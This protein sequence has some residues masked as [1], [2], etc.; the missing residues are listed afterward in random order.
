MSGCGGTVPCYHHVPSECTHEVLGADNDGVLATRRTDVH[1]TLELN[2]PERV[3]GIQVRGEGSSWARRVQVSGVSPAGQF[4][5][6]DE[7]RPLAANWD[8][9]HTVRSY[10]QNPVETIAV[11]LDPQEVEGSPVQTFT[12][13]ALVERCDAAPVAAFYQQLRVCD[14][15]KCQAYCHKACGCEGEFQDFCNRNKAADPTCTVDCSRAWRCCSNLL[16][17]GVALLCLWRAVA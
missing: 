3:V 1:L 12:A 8:G 6:V 13:D 11:T 9:V 14:A 15:L 2:Q 10:F 17:L 16:W 7:G 5:L 4:L